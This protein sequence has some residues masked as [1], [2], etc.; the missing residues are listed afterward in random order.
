MLHPTVAVQLLIF[1][2]LGFNV[3]AL[4]APVHLDKS[5]TGRGG[6]QVLGYTAGTN[7]FSALTKPNTDLQPE[8][9]GLGHYYANG[10]N[11]TI[12]LEDRTSPID[13]TVLKAPRS[14]NDLLRPIREPPVK[15][16][17]FVELPKGPIP[18]AEKDTK[19]LSILIDKST[20]FINGA[21]LVSDASTQIFGAS[22]TIP[23]TGI[24][25]NFKVKG[26]FGEAQ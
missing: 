12:L 7:T 18:S 4:A 11:P 2:T 26:L 3:P 13:N 17:P 22:A 24:I 16:K 9:Q 25:G 15:I 14:D 23:D 20:S 8:H 6:T 5:L 1:T 21:N 10:A 19:D